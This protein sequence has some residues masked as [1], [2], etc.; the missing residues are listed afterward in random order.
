[1][2]GLDCQRSET[3]PWLCPPVQV[4]G[5]LSTVLSDARRR[6]AFERR[7][8]GGA[9]GRISVVELRRCVPAD[10]ELVAAVRQLAAGGLC[11]RVVEKDGC[12]GKGM[13][14]SI[15]RCALL[16]H[17][18]CT[19][20]FPFAVLVCDIVRFSSARAC[21]RTSTAIDTNADCRP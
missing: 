6:A 1:M 20:A 8:E 17:R 11:A 3:P 2:P 18:H 7:L 15:L 9:P 19:N 5:S 14:S 21:Q 4:V 13:E 10:A 12:E 16:G